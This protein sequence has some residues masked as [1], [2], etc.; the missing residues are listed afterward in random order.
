MSRLL[1]LTRGIGYDGAAKMLCFIAESLAQRGHEVCIVDLNMYNF[2]VDYKRDVGHGVKMVELE[3]TG[4]GFAGNIDRIKKINKIS[5]EFK[6]DIIIGFGSYP[7]LYAS[8]VAKKQRI[9]SIISERA[10]PAQNM[11]KSMKSKV[12]FYIINQSQGGVFQTPGAMEYYYPKMRERGTV[13]P[14]PIFI[15]GEIPTVV[16]EE[17]EKT[18][19]SVGRLYNKQKRYDVMLNAFKMF[20]NMYPDYILKLFGLGNN[21]EEIKQWCVDLGIADKVKFMGRTAQPMQDIANAGM[22]IITSDYEGI[23]NSLLEAMAVGLPCVSTDHT[24]GG[25]RL[26]IQDHEN[27][28]L[29]PMGDAEAI[30]HALCEFAENSEL[31][32][33]C[34]ENA[35]LVTDRFAPEKIIDQWDIYISKLLQ[36][37]NTKGGII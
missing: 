22:F 18:V 6:S 12:F 37:G 36:H 26:L 9:P 3:E 2:R 4:N 1:F 14:N 25:A 31:A 34:G 16:F 29:A 24:P 17:R 23:S 21:E 8:I 15:E 27:G 30:A 13:I 33:K 19:V 32:K 28:L 10:D 5:K 35:K 20:L 11:P 7:N